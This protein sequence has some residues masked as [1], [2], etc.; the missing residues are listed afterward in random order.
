MSYWDYCSLSSGFTRLNQLK[1]IFFKPVCFD[2][3][4][5]WRFYFGQH[6]S[7]N[8]TNTG[9]AE[10]FHLF[11]FSSRVLPLF[12]INSMQRQSPWQ[13]VSRA[14]ELFRLRMLVW[15]ASAAETCMC[16]IVKHA[17]SCWRSCLWQSPPL[18]WFPALVVFMLAQRSTKPG[19]RLM[20]FCVSG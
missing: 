4:I 11:F 6:Y 8:C 2:T 13:P 20:Q 19:M 5:K 10:T 12:K 15:Q 17:D 7:V 1:K 3:E 9:P 18:S 14:M 16:Y